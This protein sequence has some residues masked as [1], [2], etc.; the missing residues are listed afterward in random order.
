MCNANDLPKRLILRKS[1]FDISINTLVFGS[2]LFSSLRKERRTANRIPAYQF[3][4]RRIFLKQRNS[5]QFLKGITLIE[6]LAA[7]SIFSLLLSLIIPGIQQAREAARR[8]QCGSQMRQLGLAAANFELTFQLVPTN[9]GFR[10]TS[11][12]KATT[13]AM[14]KISTFDIPQSRLFEWGIGS[15]SEPPHA[16]TG[17]WAFQIL[18]Y[19]VG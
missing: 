4:K 3:F 7:L 12:V 11:L 19:V 14:E 6:L 2:Q 1:S 18:P 9:G 8:M 17:C 10:Q 16:Q 15:T 13:G 5:K